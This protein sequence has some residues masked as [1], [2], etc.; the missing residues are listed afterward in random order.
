M[1]VCAHTRQYWIKDIM[2]AKPP[3]LPLDQ[4]FPLSTAALY[5]LCSF[6]PSSVRW[7]ESI[8]PYTRRLVSPAGRH[9]RHRSR[10]S[11]RAWA[12]PNLPLEFF[13][14]R[15]SHSG[16][17]QLPATIPFPGLS[18]VS[19]YFSHSS[20]D[21]IS[22]IRISPIIFWTALWLGFSMFSW[23]WFENLSPISFR[24]NLKYP[25]KNG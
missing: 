4:E 10:D 15:I 14:Q 19:E 1:R 6:Y 18:D 3:P 13:S 21:F 2:K 12:I 22:W 17:K 24:W 25:N 5:W 20:W 16:H 9:L 11:F 8:L 23:R 7:Q